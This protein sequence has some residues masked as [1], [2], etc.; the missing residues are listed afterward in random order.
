[1]HLA[2]ELLTST[3]S[4]QWWFKKFCKGEESFEDEECSG[5]PLEVDNDQLRGSP[6]LI[7]LQLHE[8]LPKNST[9]TILG[10]F[11][12]WSKLE[13]WKSS[14]RECLMSWLEKKKVL[15]FYATT[16]NHFTIKLWNAMKSG[17]YV[18]TSND[19]LSGHWISEM[20][21]QSTSQSQTWT[22]QKWS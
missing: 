16:T 5:Q 17:F 15:K 10:P 18:T 21:L 20:K 9:S 19:Q 14:I 22:P 3:Q 6:K 8:K 12:I 2:Q 7:L 13:R 11:S 1:M 4:I